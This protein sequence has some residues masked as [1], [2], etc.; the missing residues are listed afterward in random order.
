VK[1]SAKKYSRDPKASQ[2]DLTTESQV[3]MTLGQN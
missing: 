2:V 1:K 3:A